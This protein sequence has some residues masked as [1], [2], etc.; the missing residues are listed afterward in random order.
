[1]QTQRI[2]RTKWN[3]YRYFDL[4]GYWIEVTNNGQQWFQRHIWDTN[5][6]GLVIDKW[7]NSFVSQKDFE[8]F[9]DVTTNNPGSFEQY[10]REENE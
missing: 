8:L 7:V 9:T 10:S 4:Q 3:E 6:E 1:M 5:N 2:Y